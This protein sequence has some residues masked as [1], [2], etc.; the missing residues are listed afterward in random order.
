MDLWIGLEKP[1]MGAVLL[2]CDLTVGQIGKIRDRGVGVLHHDRPLEL[3]IRFQKCEILVAGLGVSY[4]REYINFPIP[5]FLNRLRPVKIWVIGEYKA[6]TFG[7]QGEQICRNTAVHPFCI[8]EF[9]G[10]ELRVDP[11]ADRRMRGDESLFFFSQG[12]G[13]RCCE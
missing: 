2:D 12:K 6:G 8:D 5:G 9:K 3:E 13:S 10:N 7:K 1:L 4:S 11:D